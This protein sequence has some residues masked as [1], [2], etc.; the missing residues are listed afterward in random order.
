MLDKILDELLERFPGM[1]IKHKE[2]ELIFFQWNKNNF[3][4]I[5]IDNKMI[6]T[7]VLEVKELDEN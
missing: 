2:E 7:Q 4:V 6:L 3:I 5:I 1:E